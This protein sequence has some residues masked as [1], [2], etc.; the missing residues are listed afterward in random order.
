MSEQRGGDAPGN[1]AGSGRLVLGV[2]VVGALLGA[3]YV[4]FAGDPEEGAAEP[5]V[6]E[7]KALAPSPEP[8]LNVPVAPPPVAVVQPPEA[9]ETPEVA[10]RVRPRYREDWTA[11]DYHAEG[12]APPMREIPPEILEEFLSGMAPIPE[13][14]R[15]LVER[16]MEEMPPR[17]REDFERAANPD[18]PPDILAE[19]ENPYPP[20]PPGHEAYFP[21]GV[22][23]PR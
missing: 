10:E 22:E 23:V 12:E 21:D 5:E 9:A 6:V 11:E 17:V 7:S 13:E 2:L 1:G 4:V 16:G 18:I 3:M 20:M 14:D 15:A 8:V 19:F